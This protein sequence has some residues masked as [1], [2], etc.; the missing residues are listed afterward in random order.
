MLR[1]IPFRGSRCVVLALLA[2]CVACASARQTGGPGSENEIATQGSG[3]ASGAET[4][5]QG[6]AQ[7]TPEPVASP[8]PPTTTTIGTTA[9]GES[10]PANPSGPE[11]ESPSAADS[12][13][14][15]PVD[16]GQERNA[17]AMGGVTA[18]A[19]PPAAAPSP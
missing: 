16:A 3:N 6:N 17:P 10:R 18:F 7:P 14:R 4:A 12:S 2:S 1:L 5:P 13:S 11:S 8:A 19:P 15:R 9:S